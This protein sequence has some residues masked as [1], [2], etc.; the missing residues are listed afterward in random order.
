MHETNIEANVAL[1]IEAW[2]RGDR[3]ALMLIFAPNAIDHNSETGASGS[4]SVMESLAAL[5]YAF[6]D[7]KYTLLE[8]AVDAKR[9]LSTTNITCEGT[10]EHEYL[11]V[12]ASGQHLTWREMRMA[13]WYEGRVSEHW[14]VSEVLGEMLL[15]RESSLG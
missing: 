13:R 10:H 8:L 4:Q 5:R 1:F 3:D 12:P 11:G 15:S 2:N 7:L 14:T 9:Q 6:P